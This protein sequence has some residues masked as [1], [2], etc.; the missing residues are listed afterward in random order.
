MT[1]TI[2][3]YNKLDKWYNPYWYKHE[4]KAIRVKI[5]RAI[6]H[7]NRQKIHCGLFEVEKE[8]KTNGWI[9]Y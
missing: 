6:R 2:R 3:W 5:H 1:H 7:L 9:S 8:T 4:L